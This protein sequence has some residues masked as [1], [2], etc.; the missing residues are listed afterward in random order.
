MHI[1]LDQAAIPAQLNH[2]NAFQTQRVAY[3]QLSYATCFIELISQLKNVSCIAYFAQGF[4]SPTIPRIF[5]LRNAI[6]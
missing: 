2:S 6:E 1:Y 3:I 5:T 4:K